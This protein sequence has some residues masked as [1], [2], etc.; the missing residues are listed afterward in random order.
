MRKGSSD[1][2]WGCCRKGVSCHH[3]RLAETQRGRQDNGTVLWWEGGCLAAPWLDAHTDDCP[4]KWAPWLREHIWPSL[5]LSESGA[6]TKTQGKC[7]LPIKFWPFGARGSRSGRQA[8]LL[9]AD[10]GSESLFT[11]V[12]AVAGL[13]ISTV[14]RYTLKRLPQV[15]DVKMARLF[16]PTLLPN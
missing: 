15:S 7:Q 8:G 6:G 9:A 13:C 4:R 10:R 12:P 3:V 1:L 2:V 11:P 5:W 16:W 14:S